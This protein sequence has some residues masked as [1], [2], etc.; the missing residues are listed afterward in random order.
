MPA[1][2]VRLEAGVGL[3][4]RGVGQHL[5]AERIDDERPAQVAPLGLGARGERA[6][7]G[8]R[9]ADPRRRPPPLLLARREQHHQVGARRPVGAPALDRRRE[10][11]VPHRAR[12]GDDQQVGVRPRRQRRLQLAHHLRRRDQ[13]LD[14]LVVV[15]PLGRDLILQL[16]RGRAR[17]LELAD[18]AAGVQRVAEA[19]AAVD[20]QRHGGA[21]RDLT[22]RRRHLGGR[23]QRLRHRQL[24]AQ[25]AAAQ[26]GRPVAQRL[27]RARRQRVEADRREHRPAALDR[28]PQVAPRAHRPAPPVAA[29]RARPAC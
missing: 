25:P 27:D 13:V 22:R 16:D 24:E 12:A 19:H 10:R 14:P 15:R 6:H 26:I 4:H 21:L 9:R 5:P 17:R 3:P 28:G 8:Q 29:P 18:R 1:L 11:L 7:R 23:Q 2:A 20:D